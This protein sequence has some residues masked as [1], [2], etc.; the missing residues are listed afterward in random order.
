MALVNHKH[1]LKLTDATDSEPRGAGA[2]VGPTPRVALGLRVAGTV[3]A[4]AV[5][6]VVGEGDHL[7]HV[8]WTHGKKTKAI[9]KKKFCHIYHN[10]Q[11]LPSRLEDAERSPFKKRETHA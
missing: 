4:A 3:P 9:H 2:S 5:A 8:H 1:C 10:S 6:G 11:N 7:E